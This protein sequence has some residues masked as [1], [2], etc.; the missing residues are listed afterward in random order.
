[1]ER[2][3]LAADAKIVSLAQGGR[4][5]R[6]RVFLHDAHWRGNLGRR[7]VRLSAMTAVD[8][9][10]LTALDA[11]LAEGSVAGA[12]RR[13]GLSASAMSRTL[14]RLRAA[15]ADPLLVR[16]GRGLA[17]TPRAIEL[18]D[19]VR[20]A[21]KE[22]MALLRPALDGPDLS[23][24]E[25]TFTIRAND[26]FVEVFGAR[27]LAAL[28]APR[29]AFDSDSRPS[30]TRTCERCGRDW[31]ISRLAFSASRDQRCASRRSSKIGS[32]AWCG[33]P[34]ASRCEKI[35][36][37]LYAH[38]AHVVASRRGIITGLSIEAL[39]ALG[40]R[41]AILAVVPDFSAVLAITKL[42]NLVALVTASFYDAITNVGPRSG[43]R[44]RAF[45][46]PVRTEPITV[47]QIWHPRL[48]ADRLT[49][50]SARHC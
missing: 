45:P 3:R 44:S 5:R 24:L 35:T 11:L 2:R 19:R 14:A 31:S 46:L 12:A 27:L 7:Y 10:L 30:P 37:E 23:G 34:P 32:L 22:A 43:R 26:G 42:R 47:S 36:P 18:R 17:P 16:A 1:M 9:N 20:E 40:L 28:T 6:R 33:R 4:G 39:A 15:T 50:G 41:R 38:C 13:L 25:R 49:V 29:L 8:L 21:A 48:D